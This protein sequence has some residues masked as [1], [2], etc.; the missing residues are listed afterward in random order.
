VREKYST[1][2]AAKKLGRTILTLQRHITAGTI[3]ARPLIEVGT[4][5]VRLW[6]DRDVEKA[7]P[8]D[9]AAVSLKATKEAL[10][11]G[12]PSSKETALPASE[13]FSATI[14]TSPSTGKAAT[15]ATVRGRAVDREGL[16]WYIPVF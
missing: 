9:S 5:K 7:L 6:S 8:P 11:Q 12:M 14:V 2:E 15:Q 3:K 10:M 13:L 1:R 16:R 4:V